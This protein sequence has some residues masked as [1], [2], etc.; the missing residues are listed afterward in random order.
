M[1]I[2]AISEWQNIYN[3]GGGFAGKADVSTV[4]VSWLCFFLSFSSR[5]QNTLGQRF[6][7]ESIDQESTF[8]LSKMALL[9]GSLKAGIK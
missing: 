5:I 8:Q 2:A 6:L 3:R 1:Y 4:I 9:N 7:S